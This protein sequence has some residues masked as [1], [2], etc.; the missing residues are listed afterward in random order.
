MK[1][2][3]K[4]H[5]DRTGKSLFREMASLR[6]RNKELEL[7]QKKFERGISALNHHMDETIARIQ[8]GHANEVRFLE[9]V[10]E[11]ISKDKIV[12]RRFTDFKT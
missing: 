7:Q 12:C 11:M 5:K 10:I 1:R 9:S 4:T 2:T 3:T 6:I 8:R